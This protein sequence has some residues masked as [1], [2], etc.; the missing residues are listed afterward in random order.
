[1]SVHEPIQL[2]PR[3]KTLAEGGLC[4]SLILTGLAAAAFV[5]QWLLGLVA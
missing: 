3:R 1:M 4:F 2:F 5:L